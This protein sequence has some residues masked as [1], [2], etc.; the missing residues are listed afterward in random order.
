[1]V[2]SVTQIILVFALALTASCKR[3]SGSV[4]ISTLFHDLAGA[5]NYQEMKGFYSHDTVGILDGAIGDG[6]LTET[7]CRYILPRFDVDT[8][9]DEV[10][11][12]VSGDRATVTLRFIR[13]PVE[14]MLG[15]SQIFKLV[16]ENGKWKIDIEDELRVVL[17]RQRNGSAAE[18]IRK[19][20]NQ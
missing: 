12:K 14:N 10:D 9:W 8:E 19:L 6:S 4:G 16:R 18:Y 3:D 1:V 2:K 11:T 7:Q 17:Q 5:R 15:Y 13:H 20:M